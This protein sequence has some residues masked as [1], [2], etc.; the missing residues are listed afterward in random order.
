MKRRCQHFVWYH[1]GQVPVSLPLPLP[2]PYNVAEIRYGL[3][4][5]PT[6]ASGPG[7]PYIG[8][9]FQGDV[10][11]LSYSGNPPVPAANLPP[12]DGSQSQYYLEIQISTYTFITAVWTFENAGMCLLAVNAPSST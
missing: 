1:L 8:L 5:L 2:A 7:G 9:Q 4:Q 10:V 12:F 3:V 6:V 11:P